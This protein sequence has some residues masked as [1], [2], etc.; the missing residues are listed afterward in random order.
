MPKNGSRVL[1]LVFAPVI[2]ILYAVYLATNYIHHD[3]GWLLFLTGELLDGAKLYV[4][5]LDPSLPFIFYFQAP[6]VWLASHIGISYIALYQIYVS[7]L[8]I[9]SLWMSWQLIPKILDQHSEFLKTSLILILAFLLTLF[10]L[11]IHGQREHIML[12]LVLP[13]I[14]TLAARVS[15][16]EI[17]PLFAVAVGIMAGAGMSFK[18]FFMII[19]VFEELFVLF[20]IRKTRL[21]RPE[22]VSIFVVSLTYSVFFLFNNS[23]YLSSLPFLLRIYAPFSLPWRQMLF[24]YLA[25]AWLLVVISAI[26]I[27]SRLGHLKHTLDILCL[28]ST[29]LFVIAFIQRKNWFYHNYPFWVVLFI[30]ASISLLHISTIIKAK[31]TIIEK[32]KRIAIIIGA[33]A[34]CVYGIDMISR[35]YMDPLRRDFRPMIR[36]INKYASE[37]PVYLMTSNITQPFPIV[38]YTEGKWK[39]RFH[40]LWPLWTLYKEKEDNNSEIMFH[41]MDKMNSDER[42]VVDSVIEDL[43]TNP[44]ALLAVDKGPQPSMGMR[45]FDFVGYFSQD[46][47]FKRLLGEYIPFGKIGSYEIY[48]PNRF[49]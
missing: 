28:A 22:N 18:P 7:C 41:E 37:K 39:V 1:W 26:L 43:I 44:P 19:W 32:A 5:Y 31:P 11:E 38:N 6:P 42:F 9:V 10:A 4:E 30:V 20:F 47:R 14:L 15:E 24:T 12:L 13:Y 2:S 27:R 21:L 3:V 36:M 49:P 23:E 29:A 35:N 25:F 8:T 48:L 34:L 46:Q 45:S 40:C 33:L 17:A 16:R